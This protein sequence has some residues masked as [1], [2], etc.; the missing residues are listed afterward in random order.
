MTKVLKVGRDEPISRRSAG[1]QTK[2]F[3]RDL[4][5]PG[6]DIQIMTGPG[7][8]L[9]FVSDMSNVGLCQKPTFDVNPASVQEG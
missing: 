6:P 1:R 5:R 7:T 4:S 9:T 2:P 8:F 3:N